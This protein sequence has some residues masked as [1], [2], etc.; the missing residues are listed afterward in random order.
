M[1]KPVLK[2]VAPPSMMKKVSGDFGEGNMGTKV[3]TMDP[4]KSMGMANKKPM[5]SKTSMQYFTNDN[6]LMDTTPGMSQ[7]DRKRR[8]SKNAIAKGI[9]SSASEIYTGVES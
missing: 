8:K 1:Q 6:L 7:E 4:K 2:Q 5:E 9:M 3:S